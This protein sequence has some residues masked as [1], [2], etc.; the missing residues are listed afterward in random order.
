MSINWLKPFF[1]SSKSRRNRLYRGTLMNTQLRLGVL[2]LSFALA[3]CIA[4]ADMLSISMFGAS[5]SSN[6]LNDTLILENTL[7]DFSQFYQ[8]QGRASAQSL[9]ASIDGRARNGRGRPVSVIAQLQA[10]VIFVSPLE[11]TTAQIGWVADVRGTISGQTVGFSN[12]ATYGAQ[13]N[14]GNLIGS[15]SGSGFIE[16]NDPPVVIDTQV[17]LSGQVPTNVPVSISAILNVGITGPRTPDQIRVDFFDSLSFD[18]NSFFDIQTPNVTVNSVNGDWLV[19]N[20]LNIVPEPASG[21]LLIGAF[22]GA[23]CLLRRNGGYSAAAS[24]RA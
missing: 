11:I 22:G 24:R 6:D 7:D 10:D 17:S 5:A 21:L 23:V 19:G 16:P 2:T 4:R 8:F 12:G 1:H 3:A 14:A 15:V 20:R 13:L 9:G 18:P